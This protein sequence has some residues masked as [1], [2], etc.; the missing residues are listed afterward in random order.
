MIKKIALLLVLYCYSLMS[1]SAAPTALLEDTNE[2]F[3]SVEVATTSKQLEKGL[4]YRVWLAPWQ[5]MVFLFSP[6]RDTTFWMKNTL[7]PLDMRFFTF[8][9]NLIAHYPYAPPCLERNCPLYHSEGRAAFVL[10]TAYPNLVPAAD[11][12]NLYFFKSTK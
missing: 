12:K 9:G 8:Q 5:G 3:W 6:P 1:F 7:I 4:M 10:E 11:L 2:Y